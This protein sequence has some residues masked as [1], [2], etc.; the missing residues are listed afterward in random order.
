MRMNRANV[1]C[2]VVD[3]LRASAVGAYGAAGCDTPALDRLASQSFVF[4]HALAPSPE[5][6]QAYR[7]VWQ[8]LHPLAPTKRAQDDATLASLLGQHGYWTMLLSDEP[9]VAEHPLAADFDESVRLAAPDEAPTARTLEETQLGRF[10]AA[11]IE[12]LDDVEARAADAPFLLWLHARGM[13]APWDAPLEF[14]NSLAD[15]EDPRPPT[16]TAVPSLSLPPDYDPDQVLGTAQAYAG[17]VMALDQCL[18]AFLEEL[19]GRTIAA[20]TLFVLVGLRGFPLGEHGT[21]GAEG[22]ALFGETV[23]IPWLM[24][25][26]DRLGALCRSQAIA[27]LGDLGPTLAAASGITWPRRDATASSADLMPVVR[28]DADTVRDHLVLVHGMGA[29]AERAIRTP[30]WHMRLT[31]PERAQL[32]VKPDDR[33]EANEISARGPE[34]VAGLSEAIDAFER[35]VAMGADVQLGPLPPPLVEPL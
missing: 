31:S 4:D 10:F 34:V 19:D 22:E 23:H 30:A 5:L 18:A 11:A 16:F 29:Q 35:L 26:P 9:R 33:W 25:F 8:G 6:D 3:R 24:R 17:Q 14:R 20:N 1:I 32:F 13:V 12:G 15:E 2:L 27:H 21:I 28:G 7:A